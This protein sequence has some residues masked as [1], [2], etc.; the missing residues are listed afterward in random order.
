M[1]TLSLVPI[2]LLG[3]VFAALVLGDYLRMTRLTKGRLLPIYPLSAI[4]LLLVSFSPL[5]GPDRWW[6]AIG[7]RHHMTGVLAFAS[8]ILTLAGIFSHL[9]LTK[10]LPVTRG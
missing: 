9:H 10:T 8:L 3:V 5:F 4:L 2:S 6:L 7:L 1:D